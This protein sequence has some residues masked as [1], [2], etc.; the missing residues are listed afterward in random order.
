M[1]LHGYR[2]PGPGRLAGLDA[3]GD[4]GPRG[5][6]TSRGLWNPQGNPASSAVRVYSSNATGPGASRTPQS[7][8]SRYV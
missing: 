4:H 6:A 5:I 2:R 7:I 8:F 1:G 3:L